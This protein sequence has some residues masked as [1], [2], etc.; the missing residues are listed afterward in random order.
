[1]R[2]ENIYYLSASICGLLSIL[3]AATKNY[4]L[5]LVVF[6]VAAFLLLKAIYEDI[7]NINF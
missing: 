2:K 3:M 4:I 5:F 1:M 6:F 7:D